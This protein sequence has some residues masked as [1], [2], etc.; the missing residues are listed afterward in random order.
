MN[1]PKV[2]VLMPA[3]NAEKY[4]GE[5]IESILNQTFT[6]FEFI[7]IDDCST[8][9]T[10]K[11]IQEYAKRDSR[12]IASHNEKNLYISKSR[13]LSIDLAKSEFLAIMDADDI[14]M[15]S[16]LE[17]QYA[18]LLNN[19]DIAAVGAYMEI[20]DETGKTMLVRKYLKEDHDLKK[21]M[22]RYSPIAQPVVMYRKSVV[23][24]FGCYSP[25]QAPAEDLY[26]WFRIGTKY[27]F[28][29]I[30]EVLL[31]YRFF[32]DSSSNKKLRAVEMKTLKMRWKAFKKQGY[33]PSFIDLIYNIAQLSTI[34]IMPVK[35]RIK[36][37]VIVRRY[38]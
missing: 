21:K 2:S 31:K 25:V 12:I 24:E 23:K 37:F 36:L 32:P 26:L 6:E 7:I 3:Y 15:P 1:T 9:N 17:K 19:T 38:L 27:K 4:I 22:F 8:D 29:N 14:S 33:K 5:A 28:A 30:Q 10:W 13:N 11:I 18:I 35:I 20:M 34:Y 16:R